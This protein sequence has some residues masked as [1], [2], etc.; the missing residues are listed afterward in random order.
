MDI[1]F[2]SC[3]KCNIIYKQSYIQE[4]TSSR[5]ASWISRSH[6]YFSGTRQTSSD[7]LSSAFET[8]IRPTRSR[9]V[10]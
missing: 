9:Q 7:T 6:W 8:C 1:L 2:I 4:M 5:A 3:L 10:Y